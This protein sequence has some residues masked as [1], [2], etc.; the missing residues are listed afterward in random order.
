MI[1]SHAQ[2][3]NLTYNAGEE[4]YEALVIFHTDEGRLRVASSFHAP[5]DASEERVRRGL[6]AN[7]MKTRNSSE[8][9]R[10]RLMPRAAQ[11]PFREP[12]ARS[13]P[14]DSFSWLRWMRAA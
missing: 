7:A 9:L 3:G 10:A 11:G 14:Y 6:L 12:P 2:I 8:G 5:L 1:Q 13:H 4:C